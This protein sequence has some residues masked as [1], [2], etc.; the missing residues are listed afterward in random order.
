[1]K[2]SLILW[3]ASFAPI[4]LILAIFEIWLERHK[5]GG[6]GDTKFKN[7]YWEDHMPL[8]LP[9]IKHWS[10]YHAVMFL[11][12]IPPFLVSGIA[13]ISCISGYNAF[14]IGSHLHLRIA[15]YALLFLAAWFGN[16]ALEDFLYFA[17]QSLT[18]WH[19]PHALRKVVIEK[20]FA[21]F[22][23][24]LPTMFGLHIPGHWLAY[25]C[26]ALVLLWIRQRFFMQ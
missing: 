1:M 26:T 22:K 19:E 8:D 14:L 15:S 17:I 24:W 4:S 11:V 25:P 6:W 7:P 2:T 12:I 20:D 10:R 13:T 9:F 5:K 3:I 23:D 16:A 21:W 18:G